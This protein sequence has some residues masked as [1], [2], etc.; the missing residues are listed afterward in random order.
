[1]HFPK[2]PSDWLPG[3]PRLGEPPLPRWIWNPRPVLPRGLSYE[4][5]LFLLD[6]YG[7]WATHRAI[8]VVPRSATK[9]EVEAT[10]SELYEATRARR[11]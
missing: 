3:D 1:M 4:D 8:A 2:S 10:A 9:D 11:G 5:Y 7:T 6:T